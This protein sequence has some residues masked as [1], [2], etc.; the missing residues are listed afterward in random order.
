[1]DFQFRHAA[2]GLP[3]SASLGI[4]YDLVGSTLGSGLVDCDRGCGACDWRR[5]PCRQFADY[6]LA[7]G[8]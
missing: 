3:G 7:A 2:P 8:R 1:M 5:F 4:S 6:A